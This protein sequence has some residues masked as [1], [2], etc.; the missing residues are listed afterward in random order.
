[1]IWPWQRPRLERRRQA[2]VNRLYAEM[3]EAPLHRRSFYRSMIMYAEFGKNRLELPDNWG[4]A[5]L[6]VEQL[7]D[8]IDSFTTV[9]NQRDSDGA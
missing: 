7:W 5:P 1:M 9:R 6:Q 3:R 2:I 4:S 8:F